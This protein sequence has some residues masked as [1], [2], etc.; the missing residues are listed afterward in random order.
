MRQSWKLL[1]VTGPGVRIP[2]S[3]PVELQIEL[4]PFKSYDLEGFF[5]YTP[6]KIFINAWSLGD[7]IGY[8][9]TTDFWVT[10]FLPRTSKHKALEPV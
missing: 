5:F 3:P 8:P 6:S 7:K 10:D 9:Q 2:L 1:T 4:K